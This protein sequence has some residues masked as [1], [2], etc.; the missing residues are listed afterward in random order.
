MFPIDAWRRPPTPTADC[1]EDQKPNQNVLLWWKEATTA[2]TTRWVDTWTQGHAAA[3][4]FLVGIRPHSETSFFRKRK[5]KQVKRKRR[6]AKESVV[7]IRSFFFSLFFTRLGQGLPLPRGINVPSPLKPLGAVINQK[8]VVKCDKEKLWLIIAVQV[9]WVQRVPVSRKSHSLATRKSASPAFHARMK[10]PVLGR[11]QCRRPSPK[12]WTNCSK[13]KKEEVWTEMEK[14][15]SFVLV[16]QFASFKQNCTIEFVAKCLKSSNIKLI[17]L[18]VEFIHSSIHPSIN[19]FV[20]PSDIRSVMHSSFQKITHQ[21]SVTHPSMLSSSIHSSTHSS[22]HS[23]IHPINHY[24]YSSTHPFINPFIL[25]PIHPS[26]THPSINQPTFNPSIHPSFIHPSIIHPS[27]H[28]PNQPSIHPPT[29]PF[30]HFIYPFISPS[31]A[32][33]QCCCCSWAVRAAGVHPV[34]SCWS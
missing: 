29:H 18:C 8:R 2:S 15:A 12:H 7:P 30:T 25:S 10:P 19:A 34:C 20:Y 14:G 17:L 22:M 23:F 3:A 11:W 33:H 5:G 32:F 13:G 1:P 6:V 4:C 24:T 26:F 16:A 21:S 9:L 27:F 31:I 28:P